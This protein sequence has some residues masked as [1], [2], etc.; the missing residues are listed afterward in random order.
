MT[1]PASRAFFGKVIL[2]NEQKIA[3]EWHKGPQL[4]FA[5]AGTG[6]TRVLTAKIAWLIECA[7]YFPNQLFAATFTNKA[8]REMKSRVESLLNISCDGLWIGTFHSLCARILRR[9]GG[10]LGYQP[11]FTI[12]DTDDQKSLI[13]SVMK[14]LE[15]D[16][17]TMTPASILGAISRCKN[18]CLT[19]DNAAETAGSYYDQELTR[20]YR[21]YQNALSSAQAMDFDDLITNTVYLFSNHPEKLHKYREQF[22]YVLVD[23]YQDTNLAQFRL[24]R[25]L[26]GSSGHIFVVGDDDQSIYGWRG[27]EVANILSF[28]KHFP[29]TRIF[30]LEENYRSTPSILDFANAA[31]AP[32]QHRSQKELWTRRPGGSPVQLARFSDDRDEANGIADAINR[33]LR[34]NAKPTDILVLF[35]TNAQ[36]RPFEDAFRKRKIPYVLVGGTSFYQR[37]EVKDCLAFLRLAVNPNDN[38]SFA[39]IANVPPRGIGKKAFEQIAEQAKKAGVSNLVYLQKHGTETFSGKARTGISELV[40]LFTQLSENAQLGES[41]ESLLRQALTT[42]GYLDVLEGDDSEASRNRVENINELFNALAIWA[43]ENPEAGLSSFLEEITLATD[44]DTMDRSEGSITL[45][46]LHSA[47]GLEAPFVYL[48]GLEDGLIPSRQNFDD[49]AKIEEERRLFY[50]GITRAMKELV[51][52]FVNQRWRFGSLMPMEPTR[53]LSPVPT[54]L[55]KLT[56]LSARFVPPPRPVRQVPPRTASVYGP[57]AARPSRTAGPTPPPQP[58]FEDYSQETVQLR[59]G[60]NVRHGTYGIGRILSISG[61]GPDTRLTVLFNNGSRKKMM[62]QFANLEIL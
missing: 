45:M 49:P 56:D 62:A 8:A 37:K 22:K 19:P 36:S 44:V 47:K 4:V 10:V 17:R 60:Q 57:V 50:V 42:T 18:R 2:N 61:F 40:D 9:E 11:G 13:R 28:E 46:T 23:E 6:K 15:I 34:D 58:A 29:G 41:P 32:N 21:Y 48:A 26:V 43:E 54:D 59:M 25:H 27:A 12:Y 39:R 1:D 53:F 52:T 38:V 30:K 3:V 31:I 33:R 5:G 16:E 14:E 24:V 35:R 20:V 7:G 55:Y 51:G